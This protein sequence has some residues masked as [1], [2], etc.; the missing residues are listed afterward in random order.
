M[1]TVLKSKQSIPL[2]K[3]FTATGTI[4]YAR[5]KYFTRDTIPVKDIHSLSTALTAL[6]GQLDCCVI[7]GQ[8][9]PDH[10]SPESFDGKFMQRHARL[11]NDVPQHWVM[12]DVDGYRT[13]LP[14][15]EAIEH[16]IQT[17]LPKAFHGCSYHWQLSSSH[18]TQG[19]EHLLKVH[20]WFWLQTPYDSATLKAWALTLPIDASVFNT[21]SIH[22]TAN[23][24][25][26]GVP[27]PVG[28][29]SGLVEGFVSDDVPLVLKPVPHAE[30][31][32]YVEKLADPDYPLERVVSEVLPLISPDLPNDE[33]VKVGMALY[34]QGGGG[35]DWLAAFDAWSEPGQS[36]TTEVCETRWESFGRT[37]GPLVTIGTLLHAANLTRG[38]AASG[39]EFE[40]MSDAPE[41]SNASRFTWDTGGSFT[42]GAPSQ[43]LIKNVMPK[44]E[45]GVLFGAPGS[46]KS[47][48]VFDMAMHIALGLEWRGNKV[49]AGRVAYLAAEGGVGFKKRMVA[50]SMD[51]GTDLDHPNFR[52]SKNAANFLLRTDAVDFAESLKEWRPDLVV[53]DTFAR[54]TPGGNENSGEDMGKAL[55]HCQLVHERTGAMVLL[56]HHSG[57]DSSK[58]ARGWSGL[59]AAADW[60]AEV[61][62]S[63]TTEV[64]ALTVTKQKDGEDGQ[65][66]GFKLKVVNIGMDEDGDV[67]SSCVVEEADA[68]GVVRQS[69][70]HLGKLEQAVV[71]MAIEMQELDGTAP[72]VNTVLTAAV[73]Q[74]PFDG[75]E[76]KRDKR[77]VNINRAYAKLLERKILREDEGR[78]YVE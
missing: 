5:A 1:L 63:S 26:E 7:R 73:E 37:S 18:G 23:P 66:Y 14:A 35:S 28:Q 72:D 47:F 13:D 46:G 64:R 27:D 6:H 19:K 9:N 56:V 29:R 21:V 54:V 20:L 70:V 43:W 12:L 8:F 76:G 33:W 74:I 25:F 59:R 2:T 55:A 65:E 42:A 78:V 32:H 44:A 58:G 50:Y 75:Q 49:N 10:S 39:D 31:E 34:H 69:K 45:L 17:Q 67:I 71:K 48:K 3:R 60:E 24:V 15:L 68:G 38:S 16:F 53:I 36:Y 30:R 62:H 40:D 52:V 4:P 61:V 11:F 57:K 22:Y 77:R 51:R 41:V